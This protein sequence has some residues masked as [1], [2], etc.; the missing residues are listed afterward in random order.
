MGKINPGLYSSKTDMWATPK[1]FYDALNKE[2]HFEL[3]P[4]CTAD[5]AKCETFYTKDDD[6]LT[7][8]WSGYR[9]WVNPPYGRS[10][11]AWVRKCYE[12]SLKGTQIAV[13]LPAR[14]D[15]AYFHDFVL[16]KARLEFIR[17]RLH[18][19]ESKQ[20][21]PFPSMLAFYNM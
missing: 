1:A 21:A 7:K 10:I 12:E 8:D 15:T 9:V 14:T 13:L 3:D 16:G 4:C 5:N 18:F 2:Y 11:S 6:G 20:G 19:N 17:G